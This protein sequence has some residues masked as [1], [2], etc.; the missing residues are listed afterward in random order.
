MNNNILLNIIQLQLMNSRRK[1]CDEE[2]KKTQMVNLSS[3][4]IKTHFSSSNNINVMI[5]YSKY[6]QK[7]KTKWYD[8]F[9]SFWFAIRTVVSSW[10]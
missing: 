2:L 5:K 3:S 4:T 1:S 7:W 9:P 6:K 8:S 10:F